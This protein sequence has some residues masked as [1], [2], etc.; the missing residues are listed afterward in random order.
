ME[1]HLES[2]VEMM[3][4][5]RESDKKTGFQKSHRRG[6]WRDGSESFKE[7][8]KHRPP[9]S[10]WEGFSMWGKVL[11]TAKCR[12]DSTK[13]TAGNT[14]P[15]N[16]ESTVLLDGAHWTSQVHQAL[17]SDQEGLGTTF[18]N[19]GGVKL[20]KVLLL[21]GGIT[22]EALERRLLRAAE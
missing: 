19:L 5:L 4:D 9:G 14:P 17:S 10:G 18:S 12:W 22:K 11:G 13:Y 6:Q 20:V 2:K 21:E 7:E 8:A 1:K 3:S 16:C 15:W